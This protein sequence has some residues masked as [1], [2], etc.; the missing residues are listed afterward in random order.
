MANVLIVNWSAH[1]GGVEKHLLMLAQALD[2]RQYRLVFASPAD[3]PFPALL[4]RA[5][6]CW[7]PVPMRSGLDPQSVRRIMSL[8]KSEAIDLVHAQQSRGLYLAGT[9]AMLAGRTAVI[10]T[11]H[12]IS[13]DWHRRA[14]IPARVRWGSNLLR[15]VFAQHV[16]AKIV[17]ISS[18][19]ARFYTD[20]LG[21][22]PEKVVVI[23]YAHPQL[24]AQS[25]IDRPAHHGPLIGTVANLTEQK[26]LPHLIEA[27][28]I[29]RDTHPAATFRLIGGGHLHETLAAQIAALGLQDRVKLLG[30]QPDATSLMAEFDIFV[31]PSLW[32]PFGMV[33]LE[34]MANGVPVVA[35]DVDGVAD[36]V[37][38]N[39]TGLLVP[40]A[41]PRALAEAIVRLLSSP[42]LGQAM[43]KRGRERCSR[44]FSIEKMT[45]R[46]A[47]VYAAAL[48][49]CRR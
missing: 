45:Q 42:R 1:F 17:A 49:E 8:I 6:Y 39:E 3:G 44:V 46:F 33:L 19:A 22:P 24:P 18:G 29:V 43:G 27:A 25:G 14:L 30:F 7:H 28:A 38:H 15:R 2:P 40:P 9:A 26:G 20:V 31:L 36:V 13:I 11:E 41:D 37:V 23:P 21:L 12:N 34:A 35:T 4:Q 32:E 10:Q 48:A 16:A 47:A 5:G